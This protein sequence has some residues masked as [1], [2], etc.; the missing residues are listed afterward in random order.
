MTKL[1]Q[2]TVHAKSSKQ[3]L[4]AKSSIVG[5]LVAVS[6]YYPDVAQQLKFLVSR[7]TGLPTRKSGDLPRQ[8]EKYLTYQGGPLGK[9]FAENLVVRLYR[10]IKRI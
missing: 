1:G 9:F 6:E 2:A 8:P 4:V 3:K 7:D 5:E 10:E